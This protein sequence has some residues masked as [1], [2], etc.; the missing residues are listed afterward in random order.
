MLGAEGYKSRQR[1]LIEIRLWLSR[2]CCAQ[3]LSRALAYKHVHVRVAPPQHACHDASVA[4]RF[5]R[6]AA[7]VRVQASCF[8]KTCCASRAS[9]DQ[10]RFSQPSAAAISL[11]PSP[12]PCLH[13]LSPM[14]LCLGEMVGFAAALASCL[15]RFVCYG[16]FLLHRYTQ[17]HIHKDMKYTHK[18]THTK[19]HTRRNTHTHM[20][21]AFA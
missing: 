4:V 6:S 17:I 8:R 7:S 20:N 10:L 14:L 9:A 11:Q 16:I 19:R 13:H 1:G 5:C 2:F 18:E 12:R 15:R 21:T 3:T